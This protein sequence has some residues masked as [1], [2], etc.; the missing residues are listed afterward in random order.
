M[1][2]DPQFLFS[3]QHKAFFPD[4]TVKTNIQPQFKEEQQ[5]YVA[6]SGRVEKDKM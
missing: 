6:K 1:F 5:P 2:S 3:N 4:G